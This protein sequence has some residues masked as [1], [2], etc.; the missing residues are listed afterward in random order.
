[1]FVSSAVEPYGSRRSHEVPCGSS[2]SY[3][4]FPIIHQMHAT[5]WANIMKAP[6]SRITRKI[7]AL[8]ICS[9]R[10]NA[11]GSRSSRGILKTPKMSISI[12]SPVAKKK[13]SYGNDAIRSSGK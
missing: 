11:R 10:R 2:I 13:S 3:A 8:D 9:S 12:D 7:A 6:I 1:M 4:A 5:Q